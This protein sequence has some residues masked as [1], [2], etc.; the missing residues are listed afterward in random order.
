LLDLNI[1]QIELKEFSR[2]LTQIEFLLLILVILYEVVPG[3]EIANPFLMTV[4][5]LVYAVFVLGFHYINLDTQQSSWKLAIETWAMIAF[6]T[7]ML[8]NTGNVN[9]PLLNPY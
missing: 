8:W 7:W 6:I 2:S 9:S 4:S 3:T 5:M 1:E